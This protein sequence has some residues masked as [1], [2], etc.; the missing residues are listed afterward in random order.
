MVFNDPSISSIAYEQHRMVHRR[1]LCTF[2]DT[3]TIFL[4]S[5]R[6]NC[7]RD[8]TNLKQIDQL[9][10]SLLVKI[11]GVISR[12]N[13]LH[14]AI[15]WVAWIWIV[16]VNLLQRNIFHHIHSIFK[17][18]SITITQLGAF[19]QKLFRKVN[20]IGLVLTL[21]DKPTFSICN[22][23]ERPTTTALILI[24]YT[25]NHVPVPPVQMAGNPQ[26]RTWYRTG[27]IRGLS[28]WWQDQ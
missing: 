21:N 24:F 8:R 15:Y 1:K 5:I 4:P 20:L 9:F 7:N 17:V 25:C 2:K 12:S 13:T 19:K 23:R 14:L 26:K 11:I 3:R 16:W 28:L 18:T 22:R 10:I 27:S 6:R